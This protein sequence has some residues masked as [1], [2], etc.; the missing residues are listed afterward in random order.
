MFLWGSWEENTK[1]HRDWGDDVE[2]QWVCVIKRCLKCNITKIYL[3][4]GRDEGCRN[5]WGSFKHRG[6]ELRDFK[7]GEFRKHKSRRK[8]KK[9]LFLYFFH[10]QSSKQIM[11]FRVRRGWRQGGGGGGGGGWFFF[12]L[13]FFPRLFSPY[14]STDV[15]MIEIP[16]GLITAVLQRAVRGLKVFK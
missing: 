9:E 16:A 12:S 10:Y 11:F 14:F 15:K 6:T 3:F 8:K 7:A 13:C 1:S 2:K 4:C 5:C